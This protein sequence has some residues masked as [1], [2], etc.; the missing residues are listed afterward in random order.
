MNVILSC[1]VTN[2]IMYLG[3]DCREQQSVCIDRSIDWLRCTGAHVKINMW[4]LTAA[5]KHTVQTLTDIGRSFRRIG[6]MTDQYSF[7]DLSVWMCKKIHMSERLHRS[8]SMYRWGF[9]TH[10]F[11]I[12]LQGFNRQRE[13]QLRCEWAGL[14]SSSAMLRHGAWL[15][16]KYN[17]NSMFIKR[18]AKA[19]GCLLIKCVTA[20]SQPWSYKLS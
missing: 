13:H 14:I 2:P 17:F 6:R 16:Y 10:Y 18:T 12:D 4:P 1:Y 15:H 3:A 9:K 19:W 7:S 20:V 5:C 8:L 11:W